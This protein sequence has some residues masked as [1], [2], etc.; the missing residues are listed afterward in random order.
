MF[1]Y[2]LFIIL[3]VKIYSLNYFRGINTMFNQVKT[4]GS[5]GPSGLRKSWNSSVG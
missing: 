1:I 2:D 4:S 5:E 3:E